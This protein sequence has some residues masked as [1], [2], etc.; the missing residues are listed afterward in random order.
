MPMYERSAS[1]GIEIVDRWPDGI[2]WMAH[3][4]ESAQRT[5]HAIRGQDGVWVFDPLDGPGVEERLNDL[6]DVAGVA[7]LSSHHS[8]DSAVFAARHDV[9]VHLPS[10]MDDAAAKIDAP[11]ERYDAP[12]GEWVELGA[13]GI[14]VRTVDPATAWREAIAY[15]RADG[16]LRVPDM[17]STVPDMTVKDERLGCYL[18]HRFAPPRAAFAD[19][20]PERILVGHGEGIAQDAP[21]ALE[22]ALDDARRYLPRALVTQAPTQIRGILGALRG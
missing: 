7:V 17:L 21:E 18:F 13:S 16:T 3:P 1:S 14:S 20:D 2:G 19:V 8:R 12:P 15:R 11:I 6:G 5:S 22:S 4:E 9:A 10:W